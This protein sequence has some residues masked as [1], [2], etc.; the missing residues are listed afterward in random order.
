MPIHLPSQT[1]ASTFLKYKTEYMD[2][3]SSKDID[4]LIFSVKNLIFVSNKTS[5][6]AKKQKSLMKGNQ[7]LYILIALSR[8]TLQKSRSLSHKQLK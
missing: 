2:S 4:N 6:L 8:I 3:F 1:V 7:S 5:N